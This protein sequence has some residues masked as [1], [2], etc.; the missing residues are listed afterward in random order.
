MN[1]DDDTILARKRWR[2]S[3]DLVSRI[4]SDRFSGGWNGDGDSD[5]RLRPRPDPEDDDTSIRM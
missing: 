5:Q 3:V 1:E 2:D 4:F